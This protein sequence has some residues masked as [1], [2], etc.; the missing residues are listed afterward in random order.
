MAWTVAGDSTASDY[1]QAIDVAEGQLSGNGH[2]VY[3][4]ITKDFTDE[5]RA[6]GESSS[7]AAGGA[8]LRICTN[9][10]GTGRLAID[11]IACVPNATG[12]NAD[13]LIA[14]E[15][16]GFDDGTSGQQ[17]FAFWGGSGN[18]QPAASATYGSE[19]VYPADV[20]LYAPMYE[21]PSGTAP[22]IADRTANSHDGTANGSMTSGDVIA[23]AVGDGLDLD[24]S[25]DRINFGDITEL[26][27]AAES[28][29]SI[30]VKQDTLDQKRFIFGKDSVAGNAAIALQTWTDGNAYFYIQ[31][32]TSKYSYFDYSAA[33]TA[34]QWHLWT[35]VFDVGG[36]ANSDKAKIYIDGTSR[37]LSYSASV[38]ATLPNMSGDDFLIGDNTAATDRRWNGD[39]DETIVCDSAKSADW[40]ASYYNNTKSGSTLF[41]AGT[42]TD[43]ASGGGSATTIVLPFGAIDMLIK[44][45]ASQKWRVF[46]FDRS[47]G[48]PKTGDAANITAK[49]SKDHA[50]AAAVTDT[51]PTEI[52]DGYYDFDLTRAETNAN[53]LHL[54]PESSTTD[55]QVIGIPAA[56]H[57]RLEG[58]GGR[59]AVDAEAFSG[60]T[61]AA[62]NTEANI[63]NL[64]AT[65]SSRSTVT[66]AQV[67]TEVDTA[68]TDIGLDHL[69]S[70]SV[71]G[72]DVTD[73][74]FAALLV[75]S[76]AT[77]D[78]DDYVNTTDSL[79][80]L[81]DR[82]DSAWITATS[83][84]L[85]ADQSSVTIGTTTS[86]SNG[87]TLASSEDVYH[88]D[89]K[90]TDDDANS[91][92]EY[93][94]TWYKNAVPLTS[95][96][97]SPTIQVVKRSDGTD[98]VAST[99]M[100]EI[101]SMGSYKYD[102]S[103]NR[104]ADGEAYKVV[105]AAT[106]DSGSRTFMINVSRDSTS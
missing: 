88:A 2:D 99:A 73:D 25:D 34:G 48:T 50:A 97:T 82:G 89:I 64:D 33:V 31:D 55:I 63:G 21:D 78:F 49:I 38:P 57:T 85:N 66:T 41:T 8:T 20:V 3:W 62:D 6:T 27:S 106:I 101:G 102:E 80:A 94:V 72:A 95:G 22:Q 87:V 74:S 79:Q 16:A 86:V 35:F 61:T 93:T 11:I 70:A 92:D 40:I 37:T 36:A 7:I 67:N 10:D 76:S 30:W 71:A 39:L 15:G 5:F 59:L 26:N 90:F 65:I 83:V 98:L 58:V 53:I 60:S 46:A 17:L 28:T 100:T 105:T 96:I 91:Q 13:I 77:A 4:L 43:G 14:V 23:A 12:A 24:G 52:E 84:D 19:A 29:I 51:N 69:F 44:N 47:D 54:L 32:G 75:S 81:R 1:R 18:T 103:S 42:F 68:L 9:N 45:T 56:I 104:I